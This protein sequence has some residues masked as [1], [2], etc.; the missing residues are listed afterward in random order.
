MSLIPWW[1]KGIIVAAI[2][3][4]VVYGVHLLDA[5]RQK[6]GYDRA[7][8]EVTQRENES[9][10]F[11]LAEITRLNNQVMEATNAAKERELEA[12]KYRDR[13]LALDGKLLNTQRSIDL[14]IS[15]ATSD[16]LRNA[17]SA[18]NTLLAECR[19]KYEEMGRAAA[20]HSSDVITL[21]QAWPK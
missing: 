19:G 7:M 11:A 13:I 4:A 3:A 17:T 2:L 5:S 6:I 14:S 1:I 21:E 16:A 10:K 15:N 9:L 12:Q 18:F 8:A 20:G